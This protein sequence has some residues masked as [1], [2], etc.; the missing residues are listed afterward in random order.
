[1]IE[2]LD[3]SDDATAEA[4][5]AL[6]RRSYRVEAHRIGYERI[7]PLVET[8]EDLRRCGEQFLGWRESGALAAAISF[9]REGDLV[10]IHRLVVDP[11]WF[12]RGLARRLVRAVLALP[13]ASR[14]IVSTGEANLPARRLYESERFRLVETVTLADGLRIA[15]FEWGARAA[16]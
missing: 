16:G 5:F 15:R 4:V 8:L 9:K 7:P 12:R 6:Q 13:G 3:L 1:M 2:R 10:D 14:V 11:A